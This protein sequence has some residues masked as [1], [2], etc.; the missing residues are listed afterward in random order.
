MPPERTESVR[1]AFS[2]LVVLPSLL[3]ATSGYSRVSVC[4]QVKTQARALEHAVRAF[5]VEHRRLPR[6]LP[7]ALSGYGTPEAHLDPWGN[8]YLLTTTANEPI[9]R[10]AG[11]DGQFHTTDDWEHGMPHC[12]TWSQPE[13]RSW[14]PLTLPVL[15]LLVVLLVR[16]RRRLKRR[17][18]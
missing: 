2:F 9:L 4:D 11:P 3:C 17:A 7:E 16:V 18:A 14:W 8:P 6:D 15:P 13:T 12:P 5:E 1:I 10:T